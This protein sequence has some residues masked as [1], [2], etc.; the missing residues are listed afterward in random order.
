MQKSIR[1]PKN[2]P[3][4]GPSELV[5]ESGYVRCADES[6]QGKLPEPRAVFPVQGIDGVGEI[7]EDELI[8]MPCGDGEEQA[9]TP[10]FATLSLPANTFGV[11]GPLYK[12]FSFPCLVPT[13]RGGP[14]S[15][16]WT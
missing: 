12:P 3:E 16:V 5:G 4:G 9:A 7:D 15:R 2:F 1:P 14:M 6:R 10:G 11:S 13:L 8:C